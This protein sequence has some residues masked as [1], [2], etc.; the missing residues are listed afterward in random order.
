S[1]NASELLR[2]VRGERWRELPAGWQGALPFRYH[3]GPGP[4]RARLIVTTDTK[5]A[6]YKDIWD[7]LGTI[8]GSEYPDEVVV[9]GGHRDAWG[10]GA[11]DN[12]SG[13]VSV[14]E[15]AH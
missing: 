7:V 3:V 13:T 4:V 2:D 5:T 8:T 6:P 1:A 9:I 11:T 12:V 10:P 15:A 14:L